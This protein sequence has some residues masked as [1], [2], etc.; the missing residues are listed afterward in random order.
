ME[1]PKVDKLSSNNDSR[2]TTE[3]QIDESMKKQK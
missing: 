3:E 2:K 1:T